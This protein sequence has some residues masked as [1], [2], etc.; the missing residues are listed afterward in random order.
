MACSESATISEYSDI[1]SKTCCDALK[2]GGTIRTKDEYG[3]WYTYRSCDDYLNNG[4][5]VRDQCPLTCKGRMYKKKYY[6]SVLKCIILKSI[7]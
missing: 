2:H 5:Y 4:E 1:L 7:M 6:F 3:T